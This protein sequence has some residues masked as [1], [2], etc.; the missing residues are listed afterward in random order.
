MSRAYTGQEI[1]GR[2]QMRQREKR[3]LK[4]AE[5][6][7]CITWDD[8]LNVRNEQPRNGGSSRGNVKGLDEGPGKAKRSTWHLTGQSMNHLALSSLLLP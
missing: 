7:P 8:N 5:G 1:Q 3:I 4:E 2:E 6:A